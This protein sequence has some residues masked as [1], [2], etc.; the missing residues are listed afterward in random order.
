MTAQRNPP[1]DI[2]PSS[3][4]DDCANNPVGMT[5]EPARESGSLQ[6][7]IKKSSPDLFTLLVVKRN[8]QQ[9]SSFE[10]MI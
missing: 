6:V 3:P 7:I 5:N 10:T 9:S 1:V 4:S 8:G 2:G